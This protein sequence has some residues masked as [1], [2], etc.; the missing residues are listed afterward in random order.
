MLVDGLSW[1]SGWRAPWGVPT[2]ASLFKARARLGSE[3]PRALFE[4]VAEPLAERQTAG[5]FYRDWRL[6]GIA[7][8]YL[9]LAHT[10]VNAHHHLPLHR[11]SARLRRDNQRPTA[12]SP[13][14]D[15]VELRTSGHSGCRLPAGRASAVVRLGVGIR[16]ALEDL[17]ALIRPEDDAARPVQWQTQVKHDVRSKDKYKSV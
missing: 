8:T 17:L 11:W 3:P 10:T 16:Q 15:Y 14:G 13:M 9:G 2:K 1:Q 7:G 5:A 4:Q 6:V 12:S